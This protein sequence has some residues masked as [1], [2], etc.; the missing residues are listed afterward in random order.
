MYRA[1]GSFYK[2]EWLVDKPNGKGEL[3]DGSKRISGFFQDGVLLDYET[4]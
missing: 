4:D 1:D 3:F 2:G